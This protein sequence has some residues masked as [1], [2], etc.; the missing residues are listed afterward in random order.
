MVLCKISRV[1]DAMEHSEDPNKTDLN[2]SLEHQSRRAR[3][4]C[5]RKSYPSLRVLI[6]LWTQVSNYVLNNNLSVS[7]HAIC[8]NHHK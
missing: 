2:S 5:E 3:I 1:R 8:L 6:F 7:E 4:D